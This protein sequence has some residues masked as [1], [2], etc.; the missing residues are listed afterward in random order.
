VI[1]QPHG[2]AGAASTVSSITRSPLSLSWF[3]WL[4]WIAV[5]G[6]LLTIVLSKV[7]IGAPLN[8]SLLLG[9]VAFTA[10]SNLVLTAW[11][12]FSGGS[13]TGNRRG[14]AKNLVLA[15]VMALDLMSL[16][17]LLHF[18][19]G[20]S[21]PF[22]VFYFVNIALSAV[23]LPSKWAWPVAGLAM[24]CFT[25]LFY[26]TPGSELFAVGPVADTGADITAHQ[27][28]WRQG[29]IAAFLACA[30]VTTYFITRLTTELQ[31]RGQA[32][33]EAEMRQAKS[34]RLEA[35]A[36]LAAGAGHELASPLSTIAVVAKELSNHLVGADVPASVRE[37]V[38]LIRS[39][40][41]HCRTILN[42]MAGN[43]GQVAGEEFTRLP[44]ADLLE[45]ILS[46]VRGRTAVEVELPEELTAVTISA[47]LQSLSQAIR[48]VVQ[49]A[50]DSSQNSAAVKLT[51]YTQNAFVTLQIR[52]RGE[53]MPAD[54]LAR[55]GEPFFTTKAPGRGMGLGLFL[56]RNVIER[57]GGSLQLQSAPQ[58][59]TTATVALPASLLNFR[60]V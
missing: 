12:R 13:G 42:R 15:S 48:G 37:D 36:T 45:E 2:A 52:D 55:A 32:L 17:A 54:V 58:Q 59:G 8:L 16:T 50:V 18:S 22:A 39:E 60:S 51:V 38:E 53:G 33:R 23:V 21:N 14:A 56:A 25:A 34:A 4:R 31:Q 24:A 9:I 7:V 57:L 20:A 30:T 27:R 29:M 26:V 46:G 1:E 6:Q 28:L 35:L 11:M 19:G 40:L 43:A 47:P 49:N 10:A 5:A 44:L 3:I 41:A